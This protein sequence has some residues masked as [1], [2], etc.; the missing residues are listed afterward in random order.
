MPKRIMTIPLIQEMNRLYNIYYLS[1]IDL[2]KVFGIHQS[3]VQLYIWRLRSVGRLNMA[4]KLI[5]DEKLQELLSDKNEK[6]V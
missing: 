3:T 2:S 4:Q 6:V 1:S 5:R